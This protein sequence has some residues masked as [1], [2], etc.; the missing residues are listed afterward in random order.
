LRRPVVSATVCSPPLEKS[1]LRKLSIEV[2]DLIPQGPATSLWARVMNANMAS[3][4]PQVIATW[5]EQQGHTVRYLCYTGFEDLLAEMAPARDLVFIA[6]FTRTA[7][8]A[9]AVSNYYRQR[10]AVTVLGGPHA[11][12][13]PDDACRYFDYVL[14]LTDKNIVAEVLAHCA[15]QRPLGVHLSAPRQPAELPGVAE[16]WKFVAATLAKAPVVKIVPLIASLGCPYTCSFCIDSTI[17]FQPVPVEQVAADL[18]FLRS[19]LKRPQVGWQDPNFGVR[20]DELMDAIEEAVPPGSI[21]YLAESSLSLLTEPRLQ[22]LQRLGFKALLP[23]IESW[24]DL[25]NKSKTGR[26]TG[27]QKMAQVAEHVNL[28]LRY[29]PYVQANFVLGLDSDEGAE[30]FE[31]TKRFLDRCPAVFPAYSLLTAFGEAAP[32]NLELQRAGRVLPFPFFF[33][34]NNKSMNVRPLFYGWTEFYDRLIDLSEYSFSWRSIGRRLRAQGVGVAGFMN[35]IRAISS[36]GFGRI[37]YH[38]RIRAMLEQELPVRRFFEGESSKLPSF[39][40]EAVRAKL[41]ALW[42]LLPEGGLGYDHLAF[43]HKSQAQRLTQLA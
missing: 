29:V 42:P 4:M 5:C 1:R 36:E 14:G 33:M 19:K 17:D 10:G 22:R 3:I 35:L 18:R 39:Y 9:Y 12:C 23:G 31:L 13:F 21:E 34:D 30:P 8:L 28:L 6:S 7:P 43:L 2:L 20:F 37:K 32:L 27:E 40:H 26:R 24:Y 38:R 15:P 25:G 41:G 11:R 16:R